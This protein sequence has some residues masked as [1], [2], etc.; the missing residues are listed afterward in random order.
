VSTRVLFRASVTP[1]DTSPSRIDAT[2]GTLLASLCFS[3]AVCDA[4]RHTAHKSRRQLFLYLYAEINK[5]RIHFIFFLHRFH[6]ELYSTKGGNSA[7]LKIQRVKREYTFFFRQRE[8]VH[9][10]GRGRGRV[11]LCS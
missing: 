1:L 2:V 11:V 4:H 5:E 8:S 10:E 9:I 3:R 6:F 7:K